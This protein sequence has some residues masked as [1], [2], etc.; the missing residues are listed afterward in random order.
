MPQ[1]DTR[2]PNLGRAALQELTEAQQDDDRQV[3]QRLS[4]SA[5]DIMVYI[6]LVPRITRLI[7]IKEMGEVLY[8]KAVSRNV[9]RLEHGSLE[10]LKRVHNACFL[11]LQMTLASGQYNL[12][13]LDSF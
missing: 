9:G 8:S 1:D 12:S 11:S 4:E 13:R 5:S 7:A 10:L 2:Q 3:Q 6:H